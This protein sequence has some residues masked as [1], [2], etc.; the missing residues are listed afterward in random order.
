MEH[1]RRA[2][3]SAS[4]AADGPQPVYDVAASLVGKRSVKRCMTATNVERRRKYAEKKLVATAFANTDDVLVL[5]ALQTKAGAKRMPL[6]A[7]AFGAAT[8]FQQLAENTKRLMAATGSRHKKELAH[9]IT[10]GLPPEFCQLTLAMTVNQ[11]KNAQNKHQAQKGVDD[12][13]RAQRSLA[14]A[15]YAEGMDGTTRS[16]V[17]DKMAHTYLK[18]FLS[19]SHICSGATDDR[20]RIVD[21][22]EFQWESELAAQWPGILRE[23]AAE[24]PDYVPDLE[25]RPTTGWSVFDANMLAAVHAVTSD[26]RAERMSRYAES[27]RKRNL[28]LARQK[29]TLP[30]R[31][32]AEVRASAEAI[33]L[34]TAA[35]KGPAR[36]EHD[37]YKVQEPDFR[38]FKGWLKTAGHRYTHYT[39]PHPCPLCDNG[40]TKELVYAALLGEEVVLTTAQ[41]EVPREL[42]QRIKK[43]RV[44]LRVYR[45]HVLQ[46]A[47][48]RAAVKKA[49][50][51]LQPGEAMVIRDFVNHHDHGG[52]HVKC[53]HWVLMW[54][55][56]IGAPL[57]ILKLR[58][59]CSDKAS[60]STD[61]YYQADVC[62]F[63][64]DES[65][66]H[67][68]M[69]F[70]PFHT[71]FL[72]GD[73]G[74]HFAS[75]ATMYNESTLF[76]RF[77]KKILVLFFTSYH[78]YSRA[79]GSGAED[80]RD[81][82]RDAVAG[83]PR[84]GAKAMVEMTN[85]STRPNSWAY[86]F[87]AINRNRSVFPPDKDFD[88]SK[89]AKWIKK[90]TEV[91]YAHPD[92]TGAYDGILQY[93]LVTGEGP[94]QWT[95]LVM[96]TRTD[97]TTLCDSCSTKSDK[98]VFHTRKACPAP[99]YIHD[100]PAYRDL[101]PDPDRIEG[102]QAKGKNKGP[103]KKGV[104]YRCKYT[105]C[106]HNAARFF[107]KYYTANRHML[108]VHN[109]T[110][111]EFEELQYPAVA[112][113][114]PPPDKQSKKKKQKKSPTE[115]KEE[116]EWEGQHVEEHRKTAEGLMR[117]RIKWV[118]FKRPTWEAAN[119][120]SPDLRREYHEAVATRLGRAEEER[121]QANT[122]M[123]PRRR[124]NP[125]R[126]GDPDDTI[127]LPDRV[128][129]R[130]HELIGEEGMAYYRAYEQAQSEIGFV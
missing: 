27:T 119:R 77:G 13:H 37:A 127:P 80:S 100:L 112:T 65:N 70:A 16:V 34:R 99:R 81:L 78:A 126:Q 85:E 8:H 29:G 123:R 30:P 104:T 95:D 35:R 130:A 6:C 90:W 68:P 11:Q 3:Q 84:F 64:L 111:A 91:K 92:N 72:V 113:E 42:T 63:H 108:A 5:A 74:P 43:L 41:K 102:E 110:D 109:P 55:N 40:P 128:E 73:H 28:K 4:P 61:S 125:S 10:G 50:E 129:R 118:G 17:S 32:D 116:E 9:L 114:V 44:D 48:S 24:R 46:L 121:R 36:F 94:W 22:T 88:H 122:S 15:K 57:R 53:L 23:T 120:F 71:F 33:R 54:R 39:V 25:E 67:C 12:K 105:T 14:N 1:H 7:Q 62:D 98:A 52:A 58:H 87:R 19:N 76:R 59:Y 45:L 101:V 49:E 47:K 124:Q 86:L 103:K 60:L 75:H 38:A 2:D 26:P 21:L 89:R 117:Y 93:R 106:E 79:D 20:A 51:N 83:L 97:A 115:Q 66:P 96:A 18:F 56:E 69:L 31:T 82:R 107:R